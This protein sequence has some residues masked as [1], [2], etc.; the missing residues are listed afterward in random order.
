MQELVAVR[1]VPAATGA[2]GPFNQPTNQPTSACEA[3]SKPPRRAGWLVGWL[4]KRARRPGGC[5]NSPYSYEVLHMLGSSSLHAGSSH[6]FGIPGLAW[7][8]RTRWESYDPPGRTCRSPCPSAI[9]N[10][11][12]Q[13][14]Q[15]CNHM[16]DH[17]AD[18]TR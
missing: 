3:C 1:A 17:L 11:G 4:V 7:Q 9:S 14:K 10:P 15:T 18:L 8:V 6:S 16:E 13:G 2:P 5:G 12:P